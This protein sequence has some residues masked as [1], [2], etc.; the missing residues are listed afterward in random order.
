MGVQIRQQMWTKTN[1]LKGWQKIV[2]SAS[3]GKYFRVKTFGLL[4]DWGLIALVTGKGKARAE[5]ETCTNFL[6]S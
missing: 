2:C 6:K 3:K 4:R 1:G 5:I